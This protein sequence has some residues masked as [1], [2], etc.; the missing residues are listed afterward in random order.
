MH[1]IWKTTVL[2]IIYQSIIIFFRSCR[3]LN[4]TGIYMRISFNTKVLNLLI[5]FKEV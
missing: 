4:G 1:D 2:C 3:Q 5:F